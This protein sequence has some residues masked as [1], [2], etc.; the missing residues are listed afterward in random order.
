MLQAK[1]HFPPLGMV[2][3]FRDWNPALSRLEFSYELVKERPFT[4]PLR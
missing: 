1:C 2:Y 3:G 4:V